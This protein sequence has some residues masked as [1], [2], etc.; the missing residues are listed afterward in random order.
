MQVP[1]AWAEK[2]FQSLGR[3]DAHDLAVELIVA[4]QGT[5]VLMHVLGQPKLMSDEARRLKRWIDAL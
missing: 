5:A 1:I 3:Q 2:Q 4:Y